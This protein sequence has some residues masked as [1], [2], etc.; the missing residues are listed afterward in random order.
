MADLWY[1]DSYLVDG[2]A[3]ALTNAEVFESASDILEFRKKP[4]KYT[5]YYE[6]WEDQ[7]F[8]SSEDNDNWEE[9]SEAVANDENEPN[10]T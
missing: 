8:P 6:A 1:H 2:L 10:D 9:F 4:Q 7:G 5:A 3:E